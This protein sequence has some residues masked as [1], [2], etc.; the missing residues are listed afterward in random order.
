MPDPVGLVSSQIPHYAE[1][2][3]HQIPGVCSRGG[4][5]GML[6]GGNGALGVYSLVHWRRS[7][8]SDTHLSKFDHFTL[9]LYKGREMNQTIN[10]TAEVSE[11]ETN[12]LD[13]T[14]YKGKR[15]RTESVLDLRTQT[16]QY[17]HSSTC[18][19]F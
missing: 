14:D 8:T 11:K 3:S 7:S 16:F 10:F 13:T 15:F 9:Q 18:Y 12:F 19:P 1:L 4:G 5:G 6:G 17:T 2:T